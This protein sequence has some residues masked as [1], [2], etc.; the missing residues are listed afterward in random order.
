M[1][2]WRWYAAGAIAGATAVAILWI[3]GDVAEDL[4]R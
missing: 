3:F 2:H 1:T 4:R